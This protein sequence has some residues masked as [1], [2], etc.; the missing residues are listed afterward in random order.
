MIK[1][2]GICGKAGSGKT[3][4]ANYLVNKYKVG[5]IS[6]ATPIRKM[7]YPVIENLYIDRSDQEIEDVLYKNKGK[8]IDALGTSPRKL[9]QDI[10]AL[11]RDYNEDVFVNLAQKTL[12][13]VEELNE[14][15]G[16]IVAEG[17]FQVRSSTY[18]IDDL[19]YDNEA[20]WIKDSGGLI[21]RLN[22]PEDQL[23]K[24]PKHH[25]ENGVSDEYVDH[26]FHN[27]SNVNEIADIAADIAK[28]CSVP[29][30][31]PTPIIDPKGSN[32]VH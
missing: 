26:E 1:V 17:I 12:E 28:I 31:E 9:M 8:E 11:M 3:T 4:V 25:S 21:F 22:R 18:V 27:D 29:V 23:R 7:L 24:V 32:S 19:R 6:F 30:A 15:L 14:V 13:G 5:K 16:R 10:G 2:I 20:R